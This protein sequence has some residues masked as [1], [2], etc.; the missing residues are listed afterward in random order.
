MSDNHIK[1]PGSLLDILG[2]QIQRDPSK[3][4]T[5]AYNDAESGWQ[6]PP[7]Q[8]DMQSADYGYSSEEQTEI[9]LKQI[10][11]ENT[12][13]PSQDEN[14]EQPVTTDALV[15]EDGIDQ[16]NI[17]DLIEKVNQQAGVQPPPLPEQ[18]SLSTYSEEPVS[19]QDT[20][21]SQE[22]LP[23]P[24]EFM[25]PTGPVHL[26][27]QETT[28]TMQE[29]QLQVEALERWL[30]KP[31]PQ[32]ESSASLTMALYSA[33]FVA[34]IM[35]T[36]TGVF[37]TGN[38]KSYDAPLKHISAL[39]ASSIATTQSSP[40]STQNGI[41]SAEFDG[42]GTNSST[43]NKSN[44]GSE[45]GSG[46]SGGAIAKAAT[47][48]ILLVTPSIKP[49]NNDCPL[50]S[51]NL[52][53]LPGG[54]TAIKIQSSCRGEQTVDIKYAG[55]SFKTSF[56]QRGNLSFILDCF[57]GDKAKIE[58]SYQD[59]K[60]QLKEPVLKDMNSISKIAVLWNSDQ[61]LNLHAFEYASPENT[62]GHIWEKNPL[63]VEAVNQ[64]LQNNGTGHGF[65][66]STSGISKGVTRK[67][68]VYTFMH[69]S[70]EIERPGVIKLAL[71]HRGQETNIQ[72]V[73]CNDANAS[74]MN[75]E[76][77]Q[78]IR[79]QDTS[80]EQ[81]QIIINNCENTTANKRLMPHAIKDLYVGG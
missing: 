77:I 63:S 76:V 37:I 51:T 71:G 31:V 6:T 12:P 35:L 34:V 5:D 79:N 53:A 64:K 15:A 80:R 72:K 7:E 41:Q 74:Y 20:H 66:S 81:G 30:E 60:Q 24:V 61:D 56:D 70:L 19:Q 42:S 13:H 16:N 38:Y 28:A 73:S 57:V 55:I 69:S 46:A 52:S 58:I 40:A 18:N 36:Y 29:D 47:P 11:A 49:I 1:N 14:D 23:Q 59:G 54:F 65:M 3:N 32:K 43:F 10:I 75:Y 27:N 44:S 21:Q 33:A 48:A 45:G 68:E 4:T 8:P 78:T 9:I 17:A 25:E 39:V 50:P 26:Y 62:A 2:S 67:I 22:E